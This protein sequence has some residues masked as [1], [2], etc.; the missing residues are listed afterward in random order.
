MLRI[1]F[2]QG[3]LSAGG[4]RRART[5]GGGAR[6]ERSAGLLATVGSKSELFSAFQFRRFR[7][8]PIGNKKCSERSSALHAK[9][10]LSFLERT[11]VCLSEFVL[12]HCWMPMCAQSPKANSCE[13]GGI[14]VQVPVDSP[15]AGKLK[16]FIPA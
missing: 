10:V 2:P 13:N 12:F 8:A 15:L 3:E 1:D 6:C 7:T 5:D 9:N 14:S 11:S 16:R 4:G